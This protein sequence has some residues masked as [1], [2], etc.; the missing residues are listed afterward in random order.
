MSQLSGKVALV[1]GSSSG[2]GAALATGFAERGADIVVNY[3]RNAQG[4]ERTAERVRAYGRRCLVARANVAAASEVEAMFDRIDADFGRV[5]VLVNNAGITLK[6]PFLDTTEQEW[7]AIMDTNLKGVFLCS[8]AAARRMAAAQG[9][10]IL[11]ISSVHASTTTH[12]FTAYAATKGGMEALT[13][14]MAVELGPHGIRVN[15]LRL[16][17]IQVDRDQIDPADPAYPS[18]CERIPTGRPGRVD[19]V[20]PLAALVCS[21][22]AP[23]LSAAVIPVDGG[24]EAALNTAFAKGHVDGGAT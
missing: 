14:A 13:R 20:V 6:M 12:N 7:D 24:H 18:I 17:W 10:A 4:A 15:A 11:N 8:Q 5:D 23:Y 19:D 22:A 21:D 9:G 1:T 16:G 2:I 3:C